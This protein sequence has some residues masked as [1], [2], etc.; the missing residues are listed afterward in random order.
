MTPG[1]WG[2]T[3]GRYGFYRGYWGPHIGFYGGINYGFGYVGFGYQGGYWNG[4]HFN[5]NRSVNNVNVAVVHNV[6]NHSI[7]VD[8]RARVSFNGGSH[9]INVRPRPAEMAARR[10]QHAPPMSTQIQHSQAA[11]AD[12]S[13][14]ASGPNH[15]PA[16]FAAARP[17]AADRNVRAPQQGQQH[18]QPMQQ[19]Q[20]NQPGQPQH[21]QPMSQQGGPGRTGSEG[22]V[23]TVPER[24]GP[25]RARPGTVV[26]NR[27]NAPGRPAQQSG[28]NMPAR[29]QP[30]QRPEQ[31]RPQSQQ[32]RSPQQR[33]QSRPE[34]QQRSQPRPEQQARPQPQARSQPHQEQRA[35]PAPR[36]EPSRPQ[37]HPQEHPRR[38]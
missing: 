14:F 23:R 10:E 33:P 20:R 36:Q 37:S 6:Y 22:T 5:Y 32:P 26:P 16:N 12:R 28:P 1:Y 8:N 35:A 25:V 17:L 4:G 21:N 34:P 13:Q 30:Q 2:Y 7:R 3:H 15:R 27:G 9:G 18:N 24:G 31:A 29:P 38:D 11:R 19:P